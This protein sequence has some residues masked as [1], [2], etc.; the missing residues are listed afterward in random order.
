KLVGATAEG[1]L[2]PAVLD[3]IDPSVSR[4]STQYWVSPDGDDTGSG[5]QAEPFRTIAHAIS[6][7]P[8]LVRADHVY[9]ITLTPGTWDEEISLTNRI[10]YGSLIVERST[11]DRESHR[12]LQVAFR[13]LFGTVRLRNLST[14]RKDNSGPSIRFVSCSPYMTVEN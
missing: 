9:R 12:V 2:P 7:V 10:V 14:T 1:D 6:M 5:S 11:T 13:K 8:D 3:R 4:Q